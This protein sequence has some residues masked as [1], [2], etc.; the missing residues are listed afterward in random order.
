MGQ[1]P[2][3][4]WQVS[5]HKWVDAAQAGPQWVNFR[6]KVCVKC[7]LG[8]WQDS[9]VGW[10]YTAIPR[11]KRK[12]CRVVV[13]NEFG[14]FDPGLFGGPQPSCPWPNHPRVRFAGRN[15]GWDVPRK[16]DVDVK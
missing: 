2:P 13:L 16:V 10:R 15:G 1:G 6:G 4:G 12:K 5:R 11:G 14:N 8:K 9:I 3:R 7:G